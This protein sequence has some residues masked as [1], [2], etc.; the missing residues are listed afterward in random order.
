M[1]RFSLST[2]AHWAVPVLGA[3]ALGSLSLAGFAQNTSSNALVQFDGADEA[4]AAMER[5][6]GAASAARSRVNEFEEQAR[7]ADQAFARVRA[8]TAALA[9]R[10]QQ[11]EAAIDLADA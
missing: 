4:R 1:K 2:M 7:D 5:A 8:E 10:V 6:R 3:A 11:A 9:A